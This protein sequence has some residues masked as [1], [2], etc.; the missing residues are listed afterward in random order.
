M[1]T[2]YLEAASPTDALTAAAVALLDCAAAGIIVAAPI[3]PS[4]QQFEIARELRVDSQ[5]LHGPGSADCRVVALTAMACI[6]HG[7]ETGALVV[8]RDD[9]L[10]HIH[11]TLTQVAVELDAAEAHDGPLATLWFDAPVRLPPG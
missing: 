9:A 6:R 10:P 7:L 5:I 1:V 3:A 11:A 2:H 4:F 8:T